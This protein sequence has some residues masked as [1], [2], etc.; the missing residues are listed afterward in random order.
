MNPHGKVPVL[1]TPEGDHIYE[2][3]AI[4]KYLARRY[5]FTH[6]LP[7][8]NDLLAVA[9]FDQ[10]MSSEMF[11]FCEPAATL[12]YEAFVKP[13]FLGELK[14]DAVIASAR[15]RLESYFDVCESIFQKGQKYMAGDAFSIADIS[16][17]AIGLRLVDVGEED[18][19][20]KRPKVNEWWQ[21]CLARPAIASYAPQIPKLADIKR[22]ME[23]T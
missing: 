7:P 1:T 3:R 8:A 6:L 4:A 5:D 14:D 21:R 2:A 19:L 22:A 12:L 11:Y 15:S 9:R 23:S 13:L 18:I 20:T 17:I 16:Y 10:A